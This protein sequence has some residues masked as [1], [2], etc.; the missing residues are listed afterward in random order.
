MLR[1]AMSGEE[2]VEL[3][4]RVARAA[5]GRLS[6]MLSTREAGD[7]HPFSGTLELMRVLEELV[8][9]GAAPSAER[10]QP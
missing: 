2:P 8:P 7:G 6:G 10:P 5:D 9:A 1:H 4:M 3:S